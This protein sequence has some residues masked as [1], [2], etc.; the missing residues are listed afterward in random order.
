[1]SKGSPD[2]GRAPSVG[3]HSGGGGG[4]GWVGVAG[5]TGWDS[6]PASIPHDGGGPRRSWGDGGRKKPKGL[7]GRKPGGKFSH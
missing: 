7:C 3:G 1:L 5:A 2:L 6:A 4:G